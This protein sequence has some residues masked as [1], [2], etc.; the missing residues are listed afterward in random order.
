M[1]GHRTLRRNLGRGSPAALREQGRVIGDK[2]F[3]ASLAVIHPGGI[4]GR[5]FLEPLE[6]SP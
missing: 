6:I 4:L 3:V 1:V 2:S 5:D